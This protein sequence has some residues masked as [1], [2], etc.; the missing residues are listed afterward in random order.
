MFILKAFRLQSYGHVALH[1]RPTLR[2]GPWPHVFWGAALPALTQ[3][4]LWYQGLVT[5]LGSEHPFHGCVWEQ[6]EDSRKELTEWDSTVGVLRM[7]MGAIWNSRCCGE[8]RKAWA[9]GRAWWDLSGPRR[10]RMGKEERDKGS[11]ER[12]SQTW[13]VVCCLPGA[14]QRWPL[15][16]KLNRDDAGQ[17]LGRMSIWLKLHVL[18][19]RPRTSI[20]SLQ[21]SEEPCGE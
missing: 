4:D 7:E 9:A 6:H 14:C 16:P 17:R 5:S 10:P 2:P 20:I 12:V 19:T 11:V 13:I 18:S 3:R 8:G 1:C 21:P 15:L